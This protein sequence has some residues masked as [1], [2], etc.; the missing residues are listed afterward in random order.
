[1]STSIARLAAP[2]SRREEERIDTVIGILV[3]K[4]LELVDEEKDM[5]PDP[6]NPREDPADAT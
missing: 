1:M 5:P 3:L 2:R 6:G 4:A